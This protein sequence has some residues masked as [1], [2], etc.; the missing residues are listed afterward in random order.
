VADALTRVVTGI[1]CSAAGRTHVLDVLLRY[2]DLVF[3]GDALCTNWVDAELVVGGRRYGL[4]VC[5][6]VLYA[7]DY[8]ASAGVIRIGRDG[9]VELLDREACRAAP[10]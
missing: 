1:I 4:L 10:G 8:L 2:N 3:R 9:R 5:G 6:S 7:L